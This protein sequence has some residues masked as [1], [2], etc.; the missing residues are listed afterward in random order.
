VC[1]IDS[2]LARDHVEYRNFPGQL[3]GCQPG[4]NC[5]YDWS[6]DIVGHGTHVA[7]TLTAVA[8]SVP[9]HTWHSTCCG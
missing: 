4:A 5:P 3:S 1:I 2:G 8:S 7:G 6:K 9:A